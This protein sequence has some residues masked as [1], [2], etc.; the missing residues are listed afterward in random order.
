M[1]NENTTI[2]NRFKNLKDNYSLMK[3]ELKLITT[4]FKKN[5]LLFKRLLRNY[6]EVK[7]KYIFLRKHSTAKVTE[8][9]DEINKEKY[10]IIFDSNR[11]LLSISQS[12]LSE[13]EM[14]KSEFAQSFYIDILF[15]KYLPQPDYKKKDIIIK[16]FQFPIMIKTF[17][18]GDNHIHPYT[19][20]MISGKIH[21]NI[22]TSAYYY[23]LSAENVS[24]NI[25]LNYFQKTD[26]LISSI[27]ITNYN[28]MKAKKTIEMHKI[29]L[30]SLTCS[31]VGEYSNETSM[32]IDNIRILTTYLTEECKRQ[33]LIKISNYD[34]EEYIK[35]INYTSALHDIGKMGIPNSILEKD[36]P[37]SP[38]EMEIMKTHTNIGADYIQK[39]I[40]LFKNDTTYINFLLI[41]YD[42]C[43]YHHERW[44]GNGY[45]EGLKEDNIPFAA[46]IISVVD[47]YDAMRGFRIYNHNRKT[48]S[49][50]VEEIKLQ[51]GRQ[52]DPKIVQAFLTIEEKFEKIKYSL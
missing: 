49:E 47:A 46:R 48:H 16:P 17:K 14:N 28:L 34:L 6:I 45:P 7:K 37:L 25:E 32:H 50:A 11:H 26:S 10:Q 2:K 19:H 15:E 42:I 52:F 22:K 4:A 30:I 27:S 35:D 31:L 40:E 9:I 8:L 5:R 13:I 23:L 1:N 44:D 24:S 29:M 39:I 36:G 51:N 12:L 38:E 41:P 18:N 21:Y 20:F 33:G 43:L 3:K